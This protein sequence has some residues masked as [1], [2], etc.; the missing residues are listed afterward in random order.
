LKDKLEFRF[1]EPPVERDK[2]STD[3]GKG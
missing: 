2:D 3:F 1:S